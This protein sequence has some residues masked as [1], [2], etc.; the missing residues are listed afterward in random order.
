[1]LFFALIFF[2]GMTQAPVAVIAKASV[3]EEEFD[4]GSLLVA[5]ATLMATVS[6]YVYLVF[7]M[8]KFRR[9]YGKVVFWKESAR[10]TDPAKVADPIFKLRATTRVAVAATRLKTTRRLPLPTSGRLSPLSAEQSSVAT[11]M[12]LFDEKKHPASASSPDLLSNPSRP[13]PKP[14]SRQMTFADMKHS[15]ALEIGSRKGFKNRKA[16]D[17]GF[18]DG[19][20]EPARTERLLKE[21]FALSRELPF[22]SFQQRSGSVFFRVNGASCL[23][24]GYR[25]I[26]V[27]ANMLI[28]ALGGCKPLFSPSPGSGGAMA[29]VV[30]VFSLQ[31][32]LGA[33]CFAV[34]P[35][36][37][38]F[39]S[40]L[41]GVQFSVEGLSNLLL[42]VA[43]FVSGDIKS[44]L[45]SM[46]FLIGLLGV[47]YAQHA[48]PRSE[49]WT[50]LIA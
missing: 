35:D 3:T 25:L 27:G 41:A 47:L 26:V 4:T 16:G 43:S 29:Q 8:L 10:A 18:K 17:F 34:S 39:F 38:R 2:K 33:L 7:D 14:L 9:E 11:N 19:S 30:I 6:F 15:A 12:L 40:M 37:D 36:A 23:G 50:C 44:A 28:G 24:V 31:L 5:Y 48:G 32:A 20:A 49:P 46:A 42:F 13:L 45:Q 1:M 21:P 22:D